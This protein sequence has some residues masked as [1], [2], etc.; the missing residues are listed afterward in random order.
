LDLSF[1][2]GACIE[3]L[4]L[5]F[6]EDQGLKTVLDPGLFSLYAKSMTGKKPDDLFDCQNSETT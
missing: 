2:F 1:E 6:I 4:L 5:P 3:L